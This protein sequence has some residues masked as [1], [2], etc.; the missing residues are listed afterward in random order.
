MSFA[1]CKLWLDVND[2]IV[3]NSLIPHTLPVG[4]RIHCKRLKM[5]EKLLHLRF[6]FVDF[7]AQFELEF[8]SWRQPSLRSQTPTPHSTRALSSEGWGCAAVHDAEGDDALHDRQGGQRRRRRR[9]FP[10]GEAAPKR[11]FSLIFKRRKSQWVPTKLPSI[12]KRM[13]G[14]GVAY[15]R[16]L[17]CVCVCRRRVVLSTQYTSSALCVTTHT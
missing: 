2:G 15:R 9:R 6:F 10:P 12:Q 1:H 4:S 14:L 11:K 13:K 3:T 5:G 7:G 8:S 17:S 16:T